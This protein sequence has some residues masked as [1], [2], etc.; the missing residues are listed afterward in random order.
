LGFKRLD[1]GSGGSRRYTRKKAQIA[2]DWCKS[3]G[4]RSL[5]G[6]DNGVACLGETS[7]LCGKRTLPPLGTG[8]RVIP[9]HQTA[10]R[11]GGDPVKSP[12]R[13]VTDP[14]RT[15]M[16][17]DDTVDSVV[18]L[19]QGNLFTI[20]PF[21]LSTSKTA[22]HLQRSCHPRSLPIPPFHSLRRKSYSSLRILSVLRRF[23]PRSSRI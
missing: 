6:R 19:F 7:G 17:R 10:T 21:H 20:S 14:S 9:P 18:D 22:F 2:A 13:I 23:L 16:A 4:C 12:Q 15:P 3:G 11:F 1:P 5:F 8:S